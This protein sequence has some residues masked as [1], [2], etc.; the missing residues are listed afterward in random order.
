MYSL[1]IRDG[2]VADG[3]GSPFIQADVAVNG[4]VIAAI[5]QHLGEAA[6]TVIDARGLLVA[7]GFID[8]H[9][10]TDGSV[11]SHPLAESKILQGVT[12][13]V[14][15]NCGIGAFPVNP[16][17]RDILADY[18]KMHE[19]AFPA[20]GLSWSDLSQYAPRVEG[21]GLG[22]NL[23]PL[24]AHG[25]LRIAAMGAEDR[26]PTVDE[27]ALMEK[28]LVKALQQGA[29]GL[30]TGLI[31]PPGSFAKTD[32]LIALAR[33]LTP[34]SA[35]YASHIRG[36]S[37]T[38]LDSVAEAIRI[39]KESGAPVQ[40]SHLKAIGKTNWGK[41]KKALDLIAAARQAGVDIAA[42]Q[43][44]YEASSTSL[45]ALVPQ[46]AQAGGVDELLKRLASR[47][48]NDRII[49]GI[50]RE[51]TVRGGPERV[52]VAG[53]GS[54]RN[55]AISGQTIDQIAAE[56]NCRPEAAVM[57]LLLEEDAEV[58]AVYFSISE[59]DVTA[60]MASDFVA[61]GSD[62]RGMN[63]AEDTAQATHPRSYGTF[64][65]VL[66]L[67]AREKGLISLGKA[68]YKMTG[69]PASRL[70]LSGRGLLKPGFAA[71]ITVFDAARIRDRAWFDN[72][73]Q[74][75]DGIVHVF[76]NGRAVVSEGKVT[77]QTPGRMLRK[78]KS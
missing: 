58:G 35:V 54:E 25:A 9:T 29:W 21:L 78:N 51:M 45:S 70:G 26:E 8:I 18:L 57:R 6:E 75:S 20:D 61:V 59:D 16:Y 34:F 64:P 66:G 65:R 31:Y 30:S 3:S 14:T 71:D 63:A 62:G 55:K 50:G 36:E 69:L 19:F 76:V 42:D 32:E 33:V 10:H 60:I 5:G 17:G 44:P 2:M 49:E 27:M 74:Y 23:A 41:G 13:D 4:D 37:A 39:G 43:Y 46:W 77:G 47:E 38:I 22:I 12:T 1:L 7:P 40:I 52:M 28:L 68:I 53:V 24:V 56:W 15:G 67:F 48:L 11:F 73:H 72:P